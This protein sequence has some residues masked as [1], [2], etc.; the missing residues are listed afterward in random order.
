MSNPGSTADTLKDWSARA[1][2][3]L[4]LLT[5]PFAVSP[6]NIRIG[7]ALRPVWP[8]SVEGLALAALLIS[9][10]I[11]IFATCLIFRRLWLRLVLG[12]VVIA[13]YC[14]LWFGNQLDY[15]CSLYRSCL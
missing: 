2:G 9:V 12:A 3:L 6:L 11:G 4:L 13:A 1:A 15:G 8:Q 5:A 10:A 7:Y 14:M